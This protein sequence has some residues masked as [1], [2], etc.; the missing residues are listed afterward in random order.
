MIASILILLAGLMGAGGV[1][2]LAASAHS[3][4]AAGLD[5]AGS[6]LLVHAA[7]ALA[8]AAAIS[9]GLAWRPLA[10]AGAFGLVL[11]ASLFAGDLALRAFAG[12]RLF[13]LAAPTGGVI[14]IAGWLAVAAAALVAM[15]RP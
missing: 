6:M 12:Q 9:Q 3:A 1:A 15:T 2:L 8:L 4:P 10:T 5:T 11:G 14:L 13:P 7:A